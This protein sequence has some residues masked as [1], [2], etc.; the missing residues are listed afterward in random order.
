M[1][2]ICFHLVRVVKN[3]ICGFWVPIDRAV[4]KFI[5]LLLMKCLLIKLME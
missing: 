1:V 5:S 2:T 4:L 3:Y